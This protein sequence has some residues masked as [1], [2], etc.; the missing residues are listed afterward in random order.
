MTCKGICEQYKITKGNNANSWYKKGGSRCTVCSTFMKWEGHH[1]PC[2]GYML[3]TRPK[4]SQYRQAM[5]KRR[6]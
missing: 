2:C 4:G 1:C 6:I 3:R 5:V